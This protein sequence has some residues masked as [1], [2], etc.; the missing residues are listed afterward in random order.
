[1]RI[2]KPITLDLEILRLIINL[3]PT[4]TPLKYLIIRI[5]LHVEQK[6]MEVL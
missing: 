2:Y 4:N 1:M 3:I 6:K 5:K